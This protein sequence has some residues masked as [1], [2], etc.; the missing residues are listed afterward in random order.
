VDSVVTVPE[1]LAPVCVNFQVTIVVP[2]TIVVPLSPVFSFESTP[3]PLHMTS[4]GASSDD[5]LPPPHETPNAARAAAMMIG[6]ADF[7]RTF[8]ARP[9]IIGEASKGEEQ[10]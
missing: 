1:T 4:G 9:G 3:V 2:S 10:T 8:V 6:K 7:I 5:P